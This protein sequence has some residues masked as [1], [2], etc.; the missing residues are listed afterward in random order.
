[1]LNLASIKVKVLDTMMDVE[2]FPYDMWMLSEY[3]SRRLFCLHAFRSEQPPN[4][5]E[6]LA[7]NVVC[8]GLP[9]SLEVMGSYLK[10]KRDRTFWEAAGE[11]LRAQK[12]VVDVLRIS[13]ND[14]PPQEQERFFDIACLFLELVEH[15]TYTSTIMY[16]LVEKAT[17]FWKGCGVN[18]PTSKCQN[19]MDKLFVVVKDVELFGNRYEWDPFE[20]GC[21]F[22]MH[23]QIRD[24]GRGIVEEGVGLAPE[25]GCGIM[26]RLRRCLRRIK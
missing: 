3:L 16:S 13:Y 18:V 21:V 2:A 22:E 17:H 26:K 25:V 1:M 12:E 5:L 6:D 4:S 7:E 11:V 19:L 23:D 10:D 8:G 20:R 24:L 15:F 14:L 9:L